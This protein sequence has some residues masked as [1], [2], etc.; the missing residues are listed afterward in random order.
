M[1]FDPAIRTSSPHTCAISRLD[2]RAVARASMHILAF[3][4]HEKV[5]GCIS[6][7]WPRQEKIRCQIRVGAQ[8]VDHSFF[9][10]DRCEHVRAAQDRVDDQISEFGM[11]CHFQGCVVV[12]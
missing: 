3:V 7:L 9:F 1:V 8:D 2:I 12:D 11:G 10:E 6:C 4:A 5:F